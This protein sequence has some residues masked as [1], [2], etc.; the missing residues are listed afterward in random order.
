MWDVQDKQSLDE[1][2]CGKRKEITVF[3]N[4]LNDT[5]RLENWSM[6]L[7]YHSNVKLKIQLNQKQV[8]IE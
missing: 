2:L 5:A 6:F 1:L 4:K 8:K 7:N 3:T